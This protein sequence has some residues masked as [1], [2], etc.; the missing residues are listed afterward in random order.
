VSFGGEQMKSD[1][2]VLQCFRTGEY[3]LLFATSVAEEG[4]DIQPCRVVIRFDFI[5]KYVLLVL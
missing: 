4:L 1:K 3:N 2:D 5:P